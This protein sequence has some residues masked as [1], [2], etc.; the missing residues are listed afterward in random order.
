[1][2]HRTG[3]WLNVLAAIFVVFVAMIEPP[4][5]AAVAIVLLLSLGVWAM[6]QPPSEANSRR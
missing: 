2:S 4:I 1:M 5:S 6:F 3:A